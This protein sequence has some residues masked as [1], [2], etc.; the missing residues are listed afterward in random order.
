MTLGGVARNG[1]RF[2]LLELYLLARERIEQAKADWE[3]G[4]FEK[5]LGDEREFIS[6]PRRAR[7]RD[8]SLV[9]EGSATS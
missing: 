2:I 5:V 8:A 7:T 6:C 1:L 3:A 9:S 4:R